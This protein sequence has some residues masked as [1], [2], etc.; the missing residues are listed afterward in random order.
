MEMGMRNFLIH[1]TISLYYGLRRRTGKERALRVANTAEK[2][3]LD[4]EIFFVIRFLAV[5][6]LALFWTFL[7]FLNVTSFLKHLRGWIR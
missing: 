7:V 3:I 5:G 2:I 6:G 1:K 4:I